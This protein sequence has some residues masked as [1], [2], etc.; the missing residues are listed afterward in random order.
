MPWSPTAA[1]RLT[2]RRVLV[3]ADIDSE[4]EIRQIWGKGGFAALDVAH[5]N[6]I[7]GRNEWREFDTLV[8]LSLHYGPS[9]LDMA[10]YCRRRRRRTG[11]R[12]AE[13][14]A[15]RKSG[16]CVRRGSRPRSHR[17]SGGSDSGG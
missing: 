17:Q 14:T 3:I 12:R 2:E 11:R 6:K 8:V 4:E 10:T 15:D 5:W 7:D 13:R 1:R 9:S 16:P